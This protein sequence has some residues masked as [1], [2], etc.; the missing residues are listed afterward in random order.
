MLPV[1]IDKRQ[2]AYVKDRFIDES[3]RL[4]DDV[5]NVCDIK[6][7]EGYLLTI[8]FEK[9]FDLLNHKFLVAALKKYG[10][11][12]DFI[13]WINILFKNYKSCVINGHHTTKYF[14]LNRGAWQGDPISAYLFVLALEIF[15]ILLKSN[16][17]IHGINIFN[18]EFLYTAYADD[19]TFFLK[20]LD[21][22]RVVLKML[23]IF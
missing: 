14:P 11:C 17:I 16:K 5:N 15:F 4:I 12:K 13:D 20:S 21:S 22:V 3:G 8:D 18:H 19:T 2:T 10:F 9:V 23:D 1:L 6:K 7:I